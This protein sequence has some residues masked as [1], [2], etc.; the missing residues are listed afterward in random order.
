MPAQS[1]I[2]FSQAIPPALKFNSFDRS[3]EEH[4]SLLQLISFYSLH[5]HKNMICHV[6]VRPFQMSLF[7]GKEMATRDM[8][9]LTGYAVTHAKD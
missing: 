2:F 1:F 8:S 6:H 3:L 9:A 7:G 5:I 4:V